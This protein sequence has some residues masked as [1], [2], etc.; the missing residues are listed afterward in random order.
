[1]SD[2][3]VNFWFGWWAEEIVEEVEEIEKVAGGAGPVP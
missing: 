2:Q 3:H 1:M